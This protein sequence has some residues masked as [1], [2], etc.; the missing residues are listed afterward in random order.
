VTRARLRSA[1]RRILRKGLAAV[2]P[3]SLVRA[4][5][6]VRGQTVCAGRHRF[7]K[8][9]RVFVVAVGKA[10]TSMA[11]AA[12]EALGS[13][14]T[15]AIVIAPVKPP[16]LP[17]TLGF[18]AGHPVPDAAGVRAGREVIKLLKTTEADDLVLLLLSGGASALLPAPAEGVSLRDKQRITRQLLARGASIAELNAVRKRL[19]RLKG[20]GFADLAAPAPVITLALSDVPGDD[21]G[22]IGSGPT[23]KDPDAARLAR[24]AIRRYLSADEIPQG[25]RRALE[26]PVNRG[27]SARPWG[28]VIIGAGR[29]FAKAAG[30]EARKLGFHVRV[31]V[32]A[33][34]GEAR[35]RGPEIVAEFLGL[36]GARPHCLIATGETVVTVRGRGRGGRNQELALSA[37]PALSRVGREV[38]LATLATDGVDGNSTACGGLVDDHTVI[39]ARERG[40]HIE[41]AL[42]TND[43]TAALRRLGNLLVTGP[44]GTN[45]ADLTI[46]L[47]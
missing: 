21:P 19:S 30:A 15:S 10:A 42:D 5:L 6:R 27:R 11:R 45:V 9:Q 12:H 25:I 7:T 4:H 22:T 18:V 17:R 28:A 47:G 2:E 31:R 40:V 24:K 16:R 34:A 35:V 41:K 36:R 46:V 33:L 23:I 8:P 14:V 39:R 44:T 43:S 37:T 29:T 38:V 20:G 3:G 13:L 26:R 1:A 32:D